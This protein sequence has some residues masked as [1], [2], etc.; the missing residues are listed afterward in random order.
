MVALLAADPMSGE[1]AVLAA[2]PDPQGRFSFEGL[3]PGRYY[4]SAQPSTA[5]RSRWIADPAR[6]TQIE[7]HGGSR[8]DLQLPAPTAGE[9]GR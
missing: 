3:R 1:R 2:T 9:G 5:S 8:T 4:V 6:M 7:I